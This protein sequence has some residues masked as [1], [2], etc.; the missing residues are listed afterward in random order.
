MNPEKNT[1][2]FL[3]IL[4]IVF[5]ILSYF[6]YLYSNI[7]LL[8]VTAVIALEIHFRIQH[9][10]DKNLESSDKNS[11]IANKSLEMSNKLLDNQ[12]AVEAYVDN[13]KK[14]ILIFFNKVLNELETER[15]KI[16]DRF[17]AE[18]K[19][20]DIKMEMA[21]DKLEFSRKEN[22]YKMEKIIEK[23]DNISMS[24]KVFLDSQKF[25]YSSDRL[26]ELEDKIKKLEDKING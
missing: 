2:F 20:F 1:Q 26:K 23:T 12:R 8:L 10:L 4:A 25:N 7:A 19:D 5:S 15:Q 21:L 13:F 9:N 17:L 14:D 22:Y 6:N 3:L 18:K 24:L 16:D 11:E